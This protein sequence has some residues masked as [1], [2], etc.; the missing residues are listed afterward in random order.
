MPG[1]F[2]AVCHTDQNILCSTGSK[3]RKVKC[4]AIPTDLRHR[5]K[6]KHGVAGLTTE[7]PTLLAL[8]RDGLF[9]FC[10][11]DV[12]RTAFDNTDVDAAGSFG[13]ARYVELG[14]QATHDH[15]AFA[16]RC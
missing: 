12:E 2:P 6:A 14:I 13:T 7:G 15:S 9:D 1:Y 11:I 16:I 5:F 10:S 8:D 3:I 4:S